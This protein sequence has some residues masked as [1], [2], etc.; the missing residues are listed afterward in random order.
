MDNT[1][2]LTKH[3]KHPHGKTTRNIKRPKPSAGNINTRI[4]KVKTIRQDKNYEFEKSRPSTGKNNT[5]IRKVKT[6][7]REQINTAVREIKTNHQVDGLDLSF[8]RGFIP[9]GLIGV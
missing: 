4:R 6:I 7:H 5:R 1:I 9:G 8:S 2:S 3:R